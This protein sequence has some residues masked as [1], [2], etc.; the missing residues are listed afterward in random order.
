[1]SSEVYEHRKELKRN[2]NSYRCAFTHDKRTY[3]AEIS[4][5]GKILNFTELYFINLIP[6][7]K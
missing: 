2:E 3:H 5:T 6:V 1:M 7:I 4:L